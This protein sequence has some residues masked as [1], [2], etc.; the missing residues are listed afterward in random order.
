MSLQIIEHNNINLKKWDATILDADFPCLFAMSTYLNATCANWKAMVLNDYEVI[1]PLTEN[2]KYGI[3][4]LYQPHF[5]PQLG[6]FGKRLSEKTERLFYNELLKQYRFI[7][8]EGHA[9]LRADMW[10]NSKSKTTYILKNLSALSLNQNTKRNCKKAETLGICVEVVEPTHVITHCKKLIV[11]FLK[12]TVQLKPK[13]ITTFLNLTEALLTN[14]QL[15]AF[16]AKSNDDTL[17]AIG[18]FAYN[19]K[20]IVYLKGASADKSES[21]GAMHLLMREALTHFRSQSHQWFDFGG[22]QNSSMAQ[23]YKGFGAEA[24]TYFSYRKNSLPFPLNQFKK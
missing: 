20:Q 15:K 9:H 3:N 12:N 10:K 21:N 4:Y 1:M 8:I 22:G 13:V 17:F 18:L 16:A 7:E 2:K 14:Q 19:S 6:V 23:F 24:Q 5:T 11:P